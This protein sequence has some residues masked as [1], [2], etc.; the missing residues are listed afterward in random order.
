MYI[1]IPRVITKTYTKRYSEKKRGKLRWNIKTVK[2]IQECRKG[3]TEAKSR[4][5]K[6]KASNN[7][8]DLNPNI[9]ICQQM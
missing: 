8:A 4:G 3:K 6:Q 9:S 1:V 7:M 2:I 5:N